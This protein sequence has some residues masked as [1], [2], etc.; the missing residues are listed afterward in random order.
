[1]QLFV[2]GRDCDLPAPQTVATLLEAEG[3]AG[4]RVAVEVNREI[5]PR[6]L[7]ASH[8]LHDGDRV[9]IIHAIGGG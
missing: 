7:H 8:A 2:N 5:V 3:Q 4:R 1:M 9:E 6:S